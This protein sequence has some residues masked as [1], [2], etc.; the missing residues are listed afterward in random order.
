MSKKT[1]LQDLHV[2]DDQFLD[3]CLLA[4]FEYC[5]SFPPLNHSAVSMGFT[6]KGKRQK[7]DRIG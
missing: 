2:S 5:N 6:F 1:V 4:G 7:G 3:I